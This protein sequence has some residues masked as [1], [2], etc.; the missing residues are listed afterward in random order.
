MQQNEIIKAVQDRLIEQQEKGLEKYGTYVSKKDYSLTGWMEHALQEQTDNLVYLQ[1]QQFV[2]KEI[3][4][5]LVNIRAL[6]TTG[7]SKEAFLRLR[8]LQ[9]RL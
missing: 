8:A 4:A 7:H 1:A 9:E 3:K 5:E 2:I 6:F